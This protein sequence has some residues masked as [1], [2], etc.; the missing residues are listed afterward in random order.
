MPDYQEIADV[1]D[2]Q[3]FATAIALLLVLIIGGVFIWIMKKMVDNVDKTQ[4][5]HEKFMLKLSNLEYNQKTILSY[6]ANETAQYAK[7]DNKLATVDDKIDKVDI[8]VTRIGE[9]VTKIEKKVAI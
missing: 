9:R 2:N 1:S 6:E 7:I 3:G 4:K 5:D 8:K